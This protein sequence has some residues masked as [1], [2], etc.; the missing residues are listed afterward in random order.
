MIGG[1]VLI[2]DMKMRHSNKT[3]SSMLFCAVDNSKDQSS[4]TTKGQNDQIDDSSSRLPYFSILNLLIKACIASDPFLLGEVFRS[5][6]VTCII[7]AVLIFLLTELSFFT[8]VQSWIYGRAYSFNSIWAEVFGKKSCPWIMLVLVLL[9]YFSYVIWY[10]YEFYDYLAIFITQFWPEAPSIITNQYFLNYLV[11]GVII[12]PTLF[13]KKLTNFYIMSYVSNF[14]LILGLI[15]LIAHYIHYIQYEGISFKATVEESDLQTFPSS[16]YT[17]VETIGTINSALF[18]FPILPIAIADL[19]R[20]TRSRTMSLTW[21]VSALSVIIHFLGGFFA[22]LLNPESEGDNIF[23]ELSPYNE[24]RSEIIY[25][26]I[27]IGQVATY[28]TSIF[29]TIFYTYYISRLLAELIFPQ[30]T[31]STVSVVF[32]GITLSLL[33]IGLNFLDEA[34]TSVADLIAGVLSCFLSYAVPPFLYF[35]QYRFSNKLL[36]ISSLLLLIVGVII[37]I[38]VLVCGILDF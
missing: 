14:C 37:S 25:P 15:C 12:I 24:D 28:L 4:N 9:I 34:V 20:P 19:D 35:C 13:V 11:S 8:F 7:F 27:I 33:A 36:G 22:Y 16:I 2:A 31:K 23:F 26:E 18:F 38:L 32:S 21:T 5:G 1:D 3:G 30:S 29:T 6:Y 17:A 10:Q